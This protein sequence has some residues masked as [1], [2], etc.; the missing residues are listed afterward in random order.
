MHYS[1]SRLSAL[2]V[3]WADLYNAND[4]SFRWQHYNPFYQLIV[5]MEGTVRIAA[6]E[7][8]YELH[9]GESLLLLPW[10]PHTGWNHGQQQGQFFWTQFSCSPDI[11]PFQSAHP[12]GLNSVHAEKTELRTQLASHDDLIVIP[13]QHLSRRRFELLQLFEQL[14]T[15]SNTPKGYFRYHQTLL[16][17]E[18][19]RLIATDF[20]E[21]SHHETSFTTSFITY[22]KLVNYLNNFYEQDV[23]KSKLE[24]AI[25][26]KYEYLCQ[27]F[28]KYADTTI[29]Q[30][31]HQL[32]IQRAKYLLLHSHKSVGEIAEAIG[33]QDPF[34]FSRVFK[35]LEGVS[36]QHFR[37]RQ[38]PE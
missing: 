21:Q 29:V 1:L 27:V 35:S 11:M 31:V 37:N 12:P 8:R 2:D 10:E 9:T 32:R 33:F 3:R 34:Y 20:L 38:Q 15:E 7:K 36:P 25:D 13:K 26:R 4:P 18:I 14:V 23:S 19:L 16:L 6:S 22:R 17:G 28:K 5:A 30:Y 24:S